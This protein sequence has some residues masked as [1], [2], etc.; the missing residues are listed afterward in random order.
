MQ[1]AAQTAPVTIRGAQVPGGLV[2]PALVQVDTRR[3][4]PAARWRPG[5]PVIEVPRRVLIGRDRNLRPQPRG[6]GFDSLVDQPQAAL[7]GGSGIETTLINQSG[8]GFNGAVT[9]DPSGDVG[10][11]FY[12]Q[13][14]AVGGPGSE[15]LIINKNS[16][17][18][19]GAFSTTSL[20]A[21]SGTS[22]GDATSNPQV[23]FDQSAAGG[24]GR[25]VLSEITN[26]SICM[27]I[28]QTSD[29]T[30]G[31]WFI[32]EFSAVSGGLPDYL[33]LGVWP[34]AYYASSNEL[35]EGARPAYAFD[36]GNMLLGNPARPFQAI[37]YA[38][39]TG[40]PFQLLQPADFDGGL[41]PPAGAPGILLRHNDD[42][43]HAPGCAVGGQDC[44]E[45][46]EFTV[47][48]D[49]AA[50]SSL[51]GPAQLAIAEF[52]SNLCGLTSFACVS[53]PDSSVLLDPVREPVMWR[54]QYRNFG[55]SQQLTGSFVT[56]VDGNDRHG[57]RW[58]VLERPPG[59]ASGSWSLQQ[60]GT[61]SPDATNRWMSSVALDGS[62]NLVVGFNA[63]ADATGVFPG[64]RYAG[65]LRDDPA[66]SLSQGE[67]SVIE[68]SAP[69]TTNRYGAYSALV[70]DPV[71]DC[72]FWYTAQYNPG[73]DWDTRIAS[74][75]FSD[76][77]EPGFALGGSPLTQQVC[78]PGSLQ[79]VNLNTT[80]IAGFTNPISLALSGAPGGVTA[81]FMPNPVIPGNSSQAQITL[82]PGLSAG[83]LSFDIRGTASGASPDSVALNLDVFN[84]V[85]AAPSL[86]VPA[87]GALDVDIPVMLSWSA[88]PQAGSYFV[89]V[90]TDPG[91]STVV[92]SASEAAN[93]HR[94]NFALESLTEYFWRVTANNP[95]G[96][97]TGSAVFSFTTELVPPILLVDDDDNDPDVRAFYAATLTA[98]EFDFEVFDTGNSDIEPDALELSAY[99]AVVWFTGGE[100]GGFAGPGGGAEAALGEYLDNGG[101][102]LISSQDYFLDRGPPPTAFMTDFLGLGS[103][104]GSDDGDY[105]N[106]S[107]G[108]GS[109]FAGL[110][111]YPL[112]Y[113]QPGLVDVSDNLVAADGAQLALLGNNGNGAAVA[114]TVFNSAYLGFPLEA[115]NAANRQSLLRVFFNGC[116]GLFGEV[117]F[118]DGFEAP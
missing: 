116:A 95:C 102:L 94:I 40:F 13:M 44:L 69:S 118:R 68:G 49:N 108:P 110:G 77:G 20:T 111:P 63:S 4:P 41:A 28:S 97:S 82:P 84:S 71:D 12:L 2:V 81:N 50:N 10:I 23:L 98:L 45:L 101:C 8:G 33:R 107:G 9:A 109:I 5:D 32:Y 73:A 96:D 85:P 112:D 64:I 115:L 114:R 19:E 80:S 39:F 75:Q 52:D 24:Q 103:T 6:F 3:L 7:R 99:G 18:Q 53:Q 106:V 22:C 67:F 31:G 83:M 11:D 37:S 34:D 30:G 29:P 54:A 21:G 70:V 55:N 14:I 113:T 74:F 91:F 46:W 86:Q 92:Y 66:G 56:D 57:V 17:A 26:S 93:T 42:E 90:A 89:E 65:R 27:Y 58:F 15:V 35:F 47:D 78:S 16:G 61:H 51:S 59:V 117:F 43:S 87:D 1:I 36:R 104:S 88:V 72:T 105:L 38:T 48:F 100:F 76:C 25:W 60:E 62:G 79:P